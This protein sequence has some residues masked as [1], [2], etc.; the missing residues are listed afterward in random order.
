MPLGITGV[1]LRKLT[2]HTDPRGAFTEVYSD[3]WGLALAPRQWSIVHSRART[4]RGM[5][6]HRRHAEYFLLLTGR[7]HVGLYDLREDSV[8]HG[9]SLLIELRADSASCV[10]FPA[11]IV[12]GWYFSEDSMHLQAVSEPYRSYRSDDNLGCHYADPELALTWP[13][14]AKHE[15]GRPFAH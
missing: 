13:E 9:R 2:A 10:S 15:S 11:G 7:C 3:E 5:H 14:A 12:H 1:V 8:S 4:L 6:L